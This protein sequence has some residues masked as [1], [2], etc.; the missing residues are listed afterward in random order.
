MKVKIYTIL[1]ISFIFTFLVIFYIWNVEAENKTPKI[2]IENI[3]SR[4]W[5]FDSYKSFRASTKEKTDSIWYV[6]IDENKICDENAGIFTNYTANS[7]LEF[8]SY[9]D[10]GKKICFKA[11]NSE[12]ETSY[13]ASET[14][15]GILPEA[16]DLIDTSDTWSSNTDNI[17][18]NTTPTF[19]ITCKK[20]N[21]DIKFIPIEKLFELENVKK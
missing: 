21:T 10:N 17:T 15:I 3:T 11:T 19:E 18:S 5:K 7:K 1:K 2:I 6:L 9:N 13:K 16:P 4:M 8:K 12:N 20:E 14:I